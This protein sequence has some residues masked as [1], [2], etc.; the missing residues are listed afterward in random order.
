MGPYDH[1][2]DPRFEARNPNRNQLTSKPTE[3]HWETALLALI[4]GVM[5]S[6]NL[7]RMKYHFPHYV[8]ETWLW[9]LFRQYPWDPTINTWKHTAESLHVTEQE[10]PLRRVISQNQ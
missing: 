8:Q 4:R 3:P 2:E 6:T 9:F 1:H 5:A 7:F 10:E